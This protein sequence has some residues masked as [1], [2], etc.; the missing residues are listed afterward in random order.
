MDRL[1][2]APN[3]HDRHSGSA[4]I[5]QV[6]GDLATKYTSTKFLRIV[7]TDCIPNY[8]DLRLPTLL[9]YH[10]GS[11]LQHVSGIMSLGGPRTTPERELLGCGLGGVG[12]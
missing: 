10:A 1:H 11:C 5:G 6:L 9:L 12:D 3:M 2:L 7:S 4:L 8:P